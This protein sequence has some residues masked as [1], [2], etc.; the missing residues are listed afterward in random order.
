MRGVTSDECLRPMARQD[1]SWCLT[2][3]IAKAVSQKTSFPLKKPSVSFLV[4]L[5]V[6]K[7]ASSSEKTAVTLIS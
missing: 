4:V 5:L 1:P 7:M 3:L 6:A 2:K